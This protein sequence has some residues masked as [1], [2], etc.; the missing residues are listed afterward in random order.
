A[1]VPLMQGFQ[2]NLGVNCNACHVANRATW[3]PT[4]RVSQHMWNDIF[5]KLRFKNGDPLYC[6]SCHQGKLH[7]LDRTDL[8][9]LRVWMQ[10]NFVDKLEGRDGQP[11][12]C[13][14]CHGDP[15]NDQIL[16]GW[17]LN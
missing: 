17:R 2:T 5:M 9:S 3:T 6:D 8:P 14:T 7:F 12:D 15:F 16:A 11:H 13:S 4:K 1:H 10:E